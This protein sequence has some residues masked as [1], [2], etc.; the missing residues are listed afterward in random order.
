MNRSRYCW[1]VLKTVRPLTI[2]HLKLQSK[3]KPNSRFH[4]DTDIFT[5]LNFIDHTSFYLF[6]RTYKLS[7]EKDMLVPVYLANIVVFRKSHVKIT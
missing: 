5:N 1:H 3:K 2:Y 6:F 4:V 7:S